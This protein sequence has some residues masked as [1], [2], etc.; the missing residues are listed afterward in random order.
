VHTPDVSL[1]PRCADVYE[2]ETF[3]QLN[4]QHLF[5]P[6]P[7][8]PSPPSPP[9]SPTPP[10]PPL[11]PGTPPLHND[12]AN[13][14]LFSPGE[15]ETPPVDPT[16]GLFMLSCQ[17]D[18]ACGDPLPIFTSS[19]Q[20]AIVSTVKRLM[21]TTFYHTSVCAFECDRVVH[22]HSLDRQEFTQLL[23]TGSLPSAQWS[24]PR[25]SSYQT[26]ADDGS[27]AVFGT[28]EEIARLSNVTMQECSSFVEGRKLIAMH[29]ESRAR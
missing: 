26:V 13:L 11:P 29:G 28:L 5:P 21:T 12:P 10:V 1:T 27:S 18:P 9:P 4:S 6:P 3:D 17:V 2:Q 16:T 8:P 23:T 22:S 7:S 25:L 14:R 15:L 20:M 19:S 24:Y